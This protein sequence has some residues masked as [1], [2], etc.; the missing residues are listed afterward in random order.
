MA[1]KMEFDSHGWDAAFPGMPE[2]V[3]PEEAWEINHRFRMARG[4]YEDALRRIG[5]LYNQLCAGNTE[6][7]PYCNDAQVLAKATAANQALD[8]AVTLIGVLARGREVDNG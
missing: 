7:N 6:D 8:T 5:N 1:V 4:Q 3:T 2:G